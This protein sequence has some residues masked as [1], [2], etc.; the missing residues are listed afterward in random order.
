MNVVSTLNGQDLCP[1][2]IGIDLF[3]AL[4]TDINSVLKSVF[5]PIC[6]L[7]TT[8]DWINAEAY[9][10]LTALKAKALAEELLKIL[11]EKNIQEFHWYVELRSPELTIDNELLLY[12]LAKKIGSITF[13]IEPDLEQ[14]LK[15]WL[16]CSQFPAEKIKM[17]TDKSHQAQISA[18]IQLREAILKRMQVGNVKTFT[19]D[20]LPSLI[21]YAWMCMKAGAYPIACQLLVHRMDA[22][23]MH[24]GC[25]E[26]LFMHL[27]LIRFLSHQYDKVAITEYPE[28]FETLE[29][30]TVRHLYF[31]K[32]YAATLSRHIDIAAIYFEKAGIHHEMPMTD[33]QSLYQLNLHALYLVLSKEIDKA[34]ALELKIRDHI[35]AEHMDIL[36]LKYVNYINLARVYKKLQDYS[37]SKAYYDAAYRELK[38]GGFTHYDYIYY[39]MNYGSLY[40]A[41]GQPEKALLYWL[42]AAIYWLTVENP[43]ALSWRPRIILCQE[44]MQDILTPM[45]A[46]KANAFLLHKLG[47]LQ[48]QVGIQPKPHFFNFDASEARDFSGATC[49]VSNHML[50][51]S[52]PN[53]GRHVHVP[54]KKALTEAVSGLVAHFL[55]LRQH[56]ESFTVPLFL[57]DIHPVNAKDCQRIHSV[58]SCKQFY[59]NGEWIEPTVIAAHFKL[60]ASIQGMEQK[61]NGLQIKYKRSFLDQTID[62]KDQMALLKRFL[63]EKTLAL[64]ETAL[65][66]RESFSA[67]FRKKVI[68]FE[69]HFNNDR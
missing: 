45:A 61:A 48:Q 32:A 18:L 59:L 11:E 6:T 24:R 65:E 42:K 50:L 37:T 13:A 8:N 58:T 69:P 63:D 47:Q 2:Q 51:F 43:Y 49:F 14:S 27:T 5:A 66:L 62:C 10:N 4:H 19:P 52:A 21:G 31:V 39:N 38:D 20:Q 54:A 36:G 64:S 3:T 46:H 26:Q 30:K 15:N 67:L 56:D 28:A 17:T 23:K 25:Y 12:G 55:P 40:E 34:L 57:D 68:V 53:K 29:A 9:G 44:R 16:K 22:A 41:S 33:E 7:E 60:A 1:F 35:E